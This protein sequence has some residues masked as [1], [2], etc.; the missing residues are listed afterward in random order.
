M[1]SSSKQS[2]SHDEKTESVPRRIK[3]R[4]SSPEFWIGIP[5]SSWKDEHDDDSD[6]DQTHQPVTLPKFKILI[7]GYVALFDPLPEG[8]TPSDYLSDVYAVPSAP[9]SNDENSKSSNSNGEKHFS[10]AA[11]QSSYSLNTPQCKHVEC[12]HCMQKPNLP[13]AN[14]NDYDYLHSKFRQLHV[15]QPSFHEPDSHLL[16]PSSSKS[17]SV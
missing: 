7:G 5:S 3:K 13:S 11:E 1:A 12:Q 16:N 8:M 9:P 6:T 15:E 4:N 17:N 10:L 14:T 2:S